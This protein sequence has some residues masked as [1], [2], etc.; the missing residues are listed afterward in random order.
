MLE[1]IAV[2][3]GRRRD[4]EP[5]AL[6][7]RQA[8]RVVR[9]ER[10]DLQRLDRQLEVVDRAGG[11]GPVE[12]VIDRPFDVDVA[13]HVVADEL[14]VAIAQVRDVGHL[15][16]EE[17]VDADDR[18]TA[19]EQG[20]TQVGAD[21]SGGSGHDGSRHRIQVS[22]VRGALRDSALKEPTHEREPDDLDVECDRPVLDVVQVVLEALFERR[23]AA[24]AVDLRPAG[25]AGLHLVAQH[26]L[27]EAMLELLDEERALGTRTDDRHVA[28]QD[29]PELRQFVEVEAA[30]PSARPRVARGS[31]SRAQIGPVLASASSRIERNL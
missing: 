24:P 26:V 12:H 13:C 27:R 25:D 11:A 23:V 16:G 2:D 22:N 28:A 31:S 29:V 8:E 14:E 5:R 1:R 9:A 19:V 6:G 4:D 3:L 15:A 18:M 7:E 21:E 20:F 17:V 10:P 30:Q